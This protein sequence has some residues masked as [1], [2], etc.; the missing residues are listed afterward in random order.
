MLVQG[1]IDLCFME[2]DHWV[3]VDY[4]TDYYE[5]PGLLKE[6]YAPQLRIYRQALEAI[7]RR[8]VGRTCLYGLRHGDEIE[9]E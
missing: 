3:L 6:R 7:T 8:P 5:D 1:V 2:D 4:K 9:V